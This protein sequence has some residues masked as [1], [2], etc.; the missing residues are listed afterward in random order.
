MTS[1]GLRDENNRYIRRCGDT[2]RIQRSMAKKEPQRRPDTEALLKRNVR[3]IE[4]G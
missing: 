2:P 4:G 3:G 1:T